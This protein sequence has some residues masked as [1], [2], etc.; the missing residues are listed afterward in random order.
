MKDED[1]SIVKEKLVIVP[2][3]VKNN[4]EKENS[5]SSKATLEH[6][7]QKPVEF[8]ALEIY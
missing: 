5:D 3:Y 1:D 4:L 6:E 7:E 8:E 2:V